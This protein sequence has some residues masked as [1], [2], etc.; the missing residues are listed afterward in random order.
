MVRGSFLL[1]RLI[2]A[3]HSAYWRWGKSMRRQQLDR[4]GAIRTRLENDRRHDTVDAAL[5][6]L[7]R[8]TL[9]A[10]CAPP[11]MSPRGPQR[12]PQRMPQ[13]GPQRMSQQAP[14]PHRGDDDVA[15][16]VTRRRTR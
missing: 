6:D 2:D 8:M 16:Y 11:R 15:L 5:R 1:Q 12:M 10:V 13:R 3:G 9:D 7:A 14:Q 4:L